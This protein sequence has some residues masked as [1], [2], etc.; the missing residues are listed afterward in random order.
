MDLVNDRRIW[1]DQT[2]KLHGLERQSPEDQHV[3]LDDDLMHP[4]DRARLRQLHEE[5]KRGR[6]D[7]EF[8]Y[9]AKRQGEERWIEARG[10]VIEREASGPTRIV[11]VCADVTEKKQ[12]EDLK[13]QAEERLRRLADAMPQLVWI[14]NADGIITFYNGR[15]TEY[16]G[17]ESTNQWQPMMHPDDMAPTM[18]AWQRAFAAGAEYEMEHRLERADGRFA[19]HLS[20]ASPVR[21][22]DGRIFAW[23]GTATDI[24][25]LK[26]A[27]AQAAEAARHLLLAT[28]AAE[29]FAWDTDLKGNRISWAENAA[30][31]IGCEPSELGSDPAQA[32]FFVAAHDRQ[33]IVEEFNAAMAANRD[34]CTLEFEGIRQ[35]TGPRYWRS[36]V[37]FLRDKHGELERV[38]GVTQD[39]TAQR[40][41][42]AALRVFAERLWTAEDAAGALVYD[43]DRTSNVV[44]RSGGLTNLLGWQQDEVAASPE[45]WHQLFHPDDRQRIDRL[46]PE[47][48]IDTDDRYVHEYRVRHKDGHYVWVMDSGRVFRDAA[49]KITRQ[50]GA[51]VDITKRK[52]SEET[53]RRMASLIELSFEP[54]FVWH[55][56]RGIVEWNKGAEQLYGYT[57]EEALGRDSHE[58]LS[59]DHG[60]STRELNDALFSAKSWTGEV[61]HRTKDGRV[62]TVESRHQLI[63]SDG[64]AFVLETNHDITDKKRAEAG[65]AQMAAVALASH[66]AL[67]GADLNGIIQAWNPSAERLFGYT[68]QEAIGQHIRLIAEP[69]FHN[70]QIEFLTRVGRGETIGPLDTKRRRKDGKIIDVSLAIAP[71]LAPD[72]SVTA[73]S[74]AFHDIGERKEWE[75]RQKLMSRELAHRVKNSFAVLLAILR[76]TLAQAATPEEFASA[77]AGRL[78]SLAAAQDI[79]TEGDWRSA[80]LGALARHLFEAFVPPDSDRIEIDGPLVHLRPELTAPFALLINELATNAVKYGALSNQ[81]GKVRLCWQLPTNA[82][83]GSKLVLAWRESGGP[84]VKAPRRR[85]FG[86]KLI[87]MGVPGAKVDRAFHSDGLVCT[88]ELEFPLMIKPVKGR[89]NYFGEMMEPF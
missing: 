67:Y 61:R 70:E 43:W 79:L 60:L 20:R 14:A 7:Y 41:A 48:L 18:A 47:Q 81:H 49:G 77:F 46:P 73:V 83:G 38:A 42:D 75:A 28:E 89:L 57:R 27:Q 33:R 8:T 66:D 68:A 39:V 9:R 84:P 58:L 74:A 52:Q 12:A 53:L 2:Y 32:N 87:E 15:R 11:G 10:T 55:A 65:V 40:H 72:G 30:R 80:E 62:L 69:Q 4:E 23:Y 82:N 3:V 34:T 25:G 63:E 17:A 71:V 85:G 1:S 16:A 13:R 26:R 86:S 22:E 64:E 44:W 36:F 56:T 21:G 35:S 45:S 88:V 5:L 37:S 50:A 6:N 19:W 29:M 31:I 54:I 59:S 76:S 78:H 51:T 24:D